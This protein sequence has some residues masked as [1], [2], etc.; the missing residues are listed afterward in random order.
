MNK[1]NMALMTI[2]I[3]AVLSVLT[4]GSFTSS[5]LADK[6]K[7]YKKIVLKCYKYDDEHDGHDDSDYRFRDGH[8]YFYCYLVDFND[9]NG[10]NS[11]KKHDDDRYNSDKKHDD[12]RYDN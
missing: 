2:V 3:V 8:N 1:T 11:D 9:R 5:A 7:D 12:D 10:H 6:D 4:A